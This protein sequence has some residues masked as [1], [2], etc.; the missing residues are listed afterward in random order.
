MNAT[1]KPQT[2]QDLIAPISLAP[3]AEDA[4]MAT[5]LADLLEQNLAQNPR[6][7]KD[8]DR[9]GATIVI[10]ARDAEI[11][12]TLEFLKGTLVV[13]DGVSGAPK[14]SISADSA[15]ILEL[16]MLRIVWGVPSLLDMR[17]RRLLR[18]FIAGELKIEGL[19][20]HFISL[21]RLTR[22][23]SVNV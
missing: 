3:G 8:F 21:L 5:M 22:L 6:K 2:T 19:A 4:G 20:T 9:L 15:T 11:T 18:K 23:M 1:V 12:T 14:I 16:S 17:G 7:Q 10:E 13:H